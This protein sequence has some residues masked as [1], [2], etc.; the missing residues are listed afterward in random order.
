MS[1]HVYVLAYKIF[2]NIYILQ[3]NF[4]DEQQT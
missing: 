3:G 4:D 2:Y 1:V